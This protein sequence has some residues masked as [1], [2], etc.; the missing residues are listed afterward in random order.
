L[1]KNGGGGGGKGKS[2][3]E[4]F[5]KKTLEAGNGE[6][7]KNQAVKQE[8]KN[9]RT[10]AEKQRIANEFSNCRGGGPFGKSL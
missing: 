1:K 9:A 3:L 6:K 4:R 7:K 2:G 10:W 8:G 5:R